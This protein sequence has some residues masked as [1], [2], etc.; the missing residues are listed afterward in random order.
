MASP[1]GTEQ[2]QI[3]GHQGLPRFCR[4]AKS[5]GHSP[6]SPSPLPALAALRPPM[7]TAPPSPGIA[8]AVTHV[9]HTPKTNFQAFTANSSSYISSRD[10]GRPD[11]QPLLKHSP[12][13]CTPR[14]YSLK[15]DQMYMSIYVHQCTRSHTYTRV[16]FFHCNS[17]N[18]SPKA[19]SRLPPSMFWT[20]EKVLKS[21]YSNCKIVFLVVKAN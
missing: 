1:P 17:Q 7:P 4:G 18:F 14:E 10:S 3:C 19:D 9:L 13:R 12:C 6:P 20:T 21:S 15:R 8:A 5:W 16:C 11:Q 2:G